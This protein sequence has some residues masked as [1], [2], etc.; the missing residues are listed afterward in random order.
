VVLSDGPDMKL[1]STLPEPL[2]DLEIIVS[3]IVEVTNQPESAVRRRLREDFENPGANV[4]HAFGQANLSPYIWSDD[5]N[6]FYQQSDA[7]LYELLIWNRNRLKR[8]M[9]KW[10]AKHLVKIS[11]GPMEILSIGDGLGF[12]SLYL[13]QCGHRVTYF[14]LPGYTHHIAQKVFKNAGCDITVLDDPSQIRAE[15]FDAVVCLDVLEHVPDPP[16]FVKTIT[17][18]L[19]AKGLLYV[20]APFYMIHPTHPTHLKANRRYSGSLS[21]YRQ[22]GLRLIDGQDGWNP[23][24]LQKTDGADPIPSF[25]RLRLMRLR[26][27]GVYLGLGRFWFFPFRWINRYRRRHGQWFD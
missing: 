24:V 16:D 20:H 13:T 21:L 2:D 17:G 26:L 1:P 3:W 18:Y 7:F 15:A 11:S 9:R 5:L 23:I 27:A 4:A 12:D 22:N 14:E 8:K 6:R 19:R 25:S 10:I